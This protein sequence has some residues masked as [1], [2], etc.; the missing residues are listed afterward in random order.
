MDQQLKVPTNKAGNLCLA[1]GRRRAN[2]YKSSSDS[3]VHVMAPSQHIHRHAYTQTRAHIDVHT[4]T[5]TIKYNQFVK[6]QTIVTSCMKKE[7]RRPFIPLGPALCI[8]IAP[9]SGKT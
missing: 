3:H 9:G 6:S 4:Q 7:H 2:F 1:P 5:H 8:R